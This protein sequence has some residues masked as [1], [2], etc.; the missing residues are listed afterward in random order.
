MRPRFP[1]APR[2]ETLVPLLASLLLLSLSLSPSGPEA[3]APPVPP[4]APPATDSCAA[5]AAPVLDPCIDLQRRQ[6][7]FPPLLF[8]I[9]K[10]TLR[11]Q[12]LPTLDQLAALI[13][14]HPELGPLE[15]RYHSAYIPGQEHRSLDL[16]RV[17]AEELQQF[18][19]AKGV[20]R[21]RLS[22]RGFHGT[23]PIVQPPSSDKN[24]RAEI[25]ILP[26]R[27][28]SPAQP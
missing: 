26:P 18:F 24:R 4:P 11:P 25:V 20:P 9:N 17:R 27:A 19:I 15:I 1:P 16:P 14:R 8:E 7:L 10:R 6:I 28:P 22:A 3:G 13:L 12:S 5:G 23:Q 21:D 2:K